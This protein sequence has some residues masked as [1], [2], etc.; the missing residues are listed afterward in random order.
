[1]S[2]QISQFYVAVITN[3]CLISLLVKD[4]QVTV[5]HNT[6]QIRQLQLMLRTQKIDVW[7]IHKDT[8]SKQLMSK[9][10]RVIQNSNVSTNVNTGFCFNHRNSF[11]KRIHAVVSQPLRF[12]KIFW[13]K[14]QSNFMNTLT[15]GK[16]LLPHIFSKITCLYTMLPYL[17]LWMHVCD[18][19]KQPLPWD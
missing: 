9:Q 2:N 17:V 13:K 14:M 16:Y 8:N 15:K 19:N 1:M 3:E 6:G 4:Y 7:F 18:S 12:N 11:L 5:Y 10:N